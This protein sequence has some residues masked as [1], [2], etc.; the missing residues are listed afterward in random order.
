MLRPGVD[1]DFVH[2]HGHHGLSVAR[3]QPLLHPTELVAGLP[4]G[5]IRKGADVFQR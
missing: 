4:T 3:H 2:A 5:V 1:A